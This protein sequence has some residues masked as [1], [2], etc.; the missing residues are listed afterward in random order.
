ARESPRRPWVGVGSNP[1]EATK[2]SEDM[3]QLQGKRIAFLMADEGVE[4]VEL[5]RP[6][7]AARA[8]GAEVE[9]IAPDAGEVQAFNHL[10]KAD[11]FPVD[12]RVA[13]ASAGDYDAIVLPGGVANPDALRQDEAAVAFVRDF[14]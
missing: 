10:D 3:A 9:L 1:N 7:Q 8:A 11:T 14:F 2:R 4:Q 12:R 5:E 6:W 13:E